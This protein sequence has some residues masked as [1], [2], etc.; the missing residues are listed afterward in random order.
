MVTPPLKV[1]GASPRAQAV[2]G[3]AAGDP[4]G[5]AGVGDAGGQRGAGAEG[6]NGLGRSAEAAGE[7]ANAVRRCSRDD[8]CPRDVSVVGLI[9]LGWDGDEEV[10]GVQEGEVVPAEG[11]QLFAAEHGVV[12]QEESG[13]VGR[14]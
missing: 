4:R 1:V 12:R 14:R 2:G 3:E 5:V 11:K 6:G 10:T 8:D 9:G 13:A 7:Q